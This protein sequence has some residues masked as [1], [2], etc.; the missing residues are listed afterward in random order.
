M[1]KDVERTVKEFHR[2][3][4]ELDNQVTQ[5]EK[6]GQDAALTVMAYRKAMLSF[7]AE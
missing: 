4:G 7:G 2:E 3:L 6:A 1:Q 5:V